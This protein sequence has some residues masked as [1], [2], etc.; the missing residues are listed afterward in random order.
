[1][2]RLPPHCEH[3]VSQTHKEQKTWWSEIF[4]KRK[5]SIYNYY[6]IKQW[7]QAP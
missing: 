5:K 7:Q 4:R 1:M 2:N 6:N 3:G